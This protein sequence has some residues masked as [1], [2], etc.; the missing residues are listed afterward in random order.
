M[1]CEATE[2]APR[3]Q[4]GRGTKA[5]LLRRASPC[6]QRTR[7]VLAQVVGQG[8]AELQRRAVRSAASTGLHKPAQ[9]A[10]DSFPLTKWTKIPSSEIK[11]GRQ[12]VGD[13]PRGPPLYD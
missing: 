10:G 9:K 11:V 8:E 6:A 4:S 3:E 7:G 2:H 1:L 12:K 5:E 13:V